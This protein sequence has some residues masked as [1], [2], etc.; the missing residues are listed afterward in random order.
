MPLFS[1]LPVLRAFFRQILGKCSLH[2]AFL[3]F[4]PD[5]KR[6]VAGKLVSSAGGSS[7]GVVVEQGVRARGD[8]EAWGGG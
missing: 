5:L 8:E 1:S 3:K 7:S 4:L 2:L 6:N